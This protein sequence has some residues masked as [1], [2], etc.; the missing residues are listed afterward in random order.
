MSLSAH[1]VRTVRIGQDEETQRPNLLF[2]LSIGRDQRSLRKIFLE[3]YVRETEIPKGAPV[4]VLVW[5]Y[6]SAD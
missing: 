3:R 4:P 2:E 6:G 5:E 1:K